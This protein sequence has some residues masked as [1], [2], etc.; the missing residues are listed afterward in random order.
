MYNK[1][2]RSVCKVVLV[3]SN[4]NIPYRYHGTCPMNMVRSNQLRS[5]L[6][7]SSWLI[8]YNSGIYLKINKYTPAMSD[9]EPLEIKHGIPNRIAWTVIK[10]GRSRLHDI[11]N[12]NIPLIR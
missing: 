8:P 7:L 2:E 5:T 4:I 1:F 3:L 10:T 11:S 12:L 6:I 9:I